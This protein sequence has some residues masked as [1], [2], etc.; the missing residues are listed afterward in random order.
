[1]LLV[2][3]QTAAVIA[4]FALG[5]LW[6]RHRWGT[7]VLDISRHLDQVDPETLPLL[8]CRDGKEAQPEAR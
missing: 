3:I 8:G 1:M 2:L 7:V 5:A 6:G 4:A